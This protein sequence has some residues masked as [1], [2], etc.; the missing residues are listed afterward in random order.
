LHISIERKHTENGAIA[1]QTTILYN[2][3]WIQQERFEL[4]IIFSQNRERGNSGARRRRQRLLVV[5]QFVSAISSY[6]DRKREEEEETGFLQS[7]K[8]YFF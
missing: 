8:L 5:R 1:R 4:G 3:R 7:D 2:D 6:R